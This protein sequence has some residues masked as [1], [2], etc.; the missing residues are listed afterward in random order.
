[1]FYGV[2]KK[3]I[4]ADS[5]LKLAMMIEFHCQFVNPV[6]MTNPSPPTLIQRRPKPAVKGG[7]RHIGDGVDV[8]VSVPRYG[9]IKIKGKL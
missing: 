6:V 4:T 9:Q 3:Y 1:L 7:F 5:W 2:Y 8:V